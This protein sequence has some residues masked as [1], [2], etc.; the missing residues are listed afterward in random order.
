LPFSGLGAAELAL[1]FYAGA[2]A[3]TRSAA[4][5]RSAATV[6]HTHALSFNRQTDEVVLT[7]AEDAKRISMKARI[8]NGNR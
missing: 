2:S 5:A 4:T 8:P 6:G 7:L 3:A 1:R